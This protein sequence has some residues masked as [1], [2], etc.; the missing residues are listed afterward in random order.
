MKLHSTDLEIRNYLKANIVYE[1]CC[2]DD[3]TMKFV[4][5]HF[6][7]KKPKLKPKTTYFHVLRVV[8][9]NNEECIMVSFASVKMS[10]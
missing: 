7:M 5:R 2:I 9:V 1:C 4:I 10:E 3:Q 8:C 6:Q